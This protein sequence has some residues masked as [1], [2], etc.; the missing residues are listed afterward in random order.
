M[1]DGARPA[2]RNGRIREGAAKGRISRG[3]LNSI[4]EVTGAGQ[5]CVECRGSSL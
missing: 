5:L 2:G 1:E 3:M 4:A